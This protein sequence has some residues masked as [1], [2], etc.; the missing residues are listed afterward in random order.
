M[1]GHD[2][3]FFPLLLSIY[4]SS[5]RLP[6]AHI[7]QCGFKITK[8]WNDVRFFFSGL[9]LLRFFCT[10]VMF[11]F[12]CSWYI[13]ALGHL[14]LCSNIRKKLAPDLC[15]LLASDDPK[16]QQ[17]RAMILQSALRHI[18]TPE[19]PS[20][21]QIPRLSSQLLKCQNC[22]LM[23]DVC[24][25]G[26]LLSK[27]TNSKPHVSSSSGLGHISAPR[28]LSLSSNVSNFFSAIEQFKSFHL[29]SMSIFFPWTLENHRQFPSMFVVSA[30]AQIFQMFPQLELFKTLLNLFMSF[31]LP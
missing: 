29:N 16:F 3:G 4:Q 18:S 23:S 24:F 30:S 14:L 28:H 9:G 1:M 10:K 6:S 7:S 21:A 19:Q 12:V 26:L 15:L 2:Y 5:S 27:S 11:F 8:R 17:E 22:L 31:L 20:S 13:S 25:S